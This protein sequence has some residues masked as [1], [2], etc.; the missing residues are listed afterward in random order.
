MEC[1][2]VQDIRNIAIIGS[3]HVWNNSLRSLNPYVRAM[4]FDIG[5]CV[6]VCKCEC[7]HGAKLRD[8]PQ[9]INAAAAAKMR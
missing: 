3:K 8:H 1:N 9:L 7:V 5:D 2:S 4:L 6:S